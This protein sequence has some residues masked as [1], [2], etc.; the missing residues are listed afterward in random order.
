MWPVTRSNDENNA[1]LTYVLILLNLEQRAFVWNQLL[2][3]STYV[4][5][6]YFR[7]RKPYCHADCRL[8]MLW[9]GSRTVRSVQPELPPAV[10]RWNCSYGPCC[11]KRVL[12][13]HCRELVRRTESLREFR[14]TTASI[15]SLT[16][17]WRHT[18]P[19]CADLYNK[20]AVT[21]LLKITQ[22]SQKHCNLLLINHVPQLLQVITYHPSAST[23]TVFATPW[24]R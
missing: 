12:L 22:F 15:A 18:V 9:C 21:W 13:W 14:A 8:Q 4:Y 3:K 10:H 16:K 6:A 5:S 17:S 1:N 20:H 7:C 23:L 19:E 11:C 24:S 2:V